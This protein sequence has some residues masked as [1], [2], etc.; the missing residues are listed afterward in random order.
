MNRPHPP[1]RRSRCK[2]APLFPT[3][4][5]YTQNVAIGA[6]A[7]ITVMME[8]QNKTVYPTGTITFTSGGVLLAGPTPCT[9]TKN[10]FGE[11]ACQASASFTAN[12]AMTVLAQYSGDANY[13]PASVNAIVNVD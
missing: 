2:Y 12:T 7:S 13:P 3:V 6:T 11:Y 5:P 4:T 1:V 9:S 10:S 8:S